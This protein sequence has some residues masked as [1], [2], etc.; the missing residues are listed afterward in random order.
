MTKRKLVTL[1]VKAQWEHIVLKC[2]ESIHFEPP[3]TDNTGQ[4]SKIRVTF[5]IDYKF[6]KPF[7]KFV[8]VPHDDPNM[9]TREWTCATLLDWCAQYGLSDYSAHDVYSKRRGVLKSLHNQCKEIGLP[10]LFDDEE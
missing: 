4:R 7:P 1:K 8:R 9:I 10:G 3:R 5:P 6:G 2:I